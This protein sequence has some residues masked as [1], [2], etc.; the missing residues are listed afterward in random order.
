MSGARDVPLAWLKDG[1]FADYLYP[2]LI[3]F[4]CVGG[5]ALVAAIAVLTNHQRAGAAA[6]LSA[7]IT[8]LWL[9]VQFTVMGY[10]SWLQ[11]ASAAAGVLVLLLSLPLLRHT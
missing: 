11:P 10:V 5:A 6:L 7:S 1:P 4:V 2:S 9:A 3:L 8:L